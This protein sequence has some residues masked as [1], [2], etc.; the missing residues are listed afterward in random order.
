VGEIIFQQ[1]EMYDAEKRTTPV[2]LGYAHALT[3]TIEI[4]LPDNYV[5]KNLN[6]LH[7]NETIKE[8]GEVV[9]GF[10]V[11][12]NQEGNKIKIVVSEDYKKVT[13]PVEEYD[14][15]KKIINTAA[16]FN[17]VVLVLDKKS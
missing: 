17:K 14:S 11:T 4:N 3:R 13:Y 5:V 6:D 7:F 2:E 1:A 15:F 16:D 9:A 12:Y 8:N 10:A